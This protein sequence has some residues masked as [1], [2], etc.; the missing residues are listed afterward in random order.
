V[1]RASLAALAVVIVTGCGSSGS[2]EAAALLTDAAEETREA[3]SARLSLTT[4]IELEGGEIMVSGEGAYDRDEGKSRLDYSLSGGE[5]TLGFELVLL[6]DV[7]YQRFPP[8][9]AERDLPAGKPWVSYPLD[10]FGLTFP[11]NVL[12]RL[13]SDPTSLVFGAQEDS[14]VNRI[15][16]DEIRGVETTR[17]RLILDVPRRD[18][19][20]LDDQ[21]RERLRELRES[22]V[23]DIVVEVWVD[24]ERLIRRAD[25]RYE[26]AAFEGTTADIQSSVELYDFGAEISVAPPAAD[27]VTPHAELV[28]RAGQP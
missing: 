12:S 27:E 11:A 16:T 9:I 21:T 3:G 28:E 13:A 2:E 19:P 15:G 7:M 18:E 25:T 20:S 8:L 4:R 5:Q 17:Y 24:A 26:N 14:Q 22:G 23:D 6:G 10:E 1:R